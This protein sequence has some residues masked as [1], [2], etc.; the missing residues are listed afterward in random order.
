MIKVSRMEPGKPR[1]DERHREPA[2]PRWVKLAAALAVAVVLLAALVI[3]LDRG[4]HGPGRH[5]AD[6]DTGG[7][8][9]E[10]R[11]GRPPGVIRGRA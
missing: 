7:E 3:L 11:S 6:G 2:T 9:F 8:T 1:I 10:G 4:D 5:A